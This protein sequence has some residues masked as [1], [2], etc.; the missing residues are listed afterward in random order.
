MFTIVKIRERLTGDGDPGWYD[1]P[2]GTVASPATT[3]QLGRDGVVV[4]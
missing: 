1:H 4:D 3:A 2:G